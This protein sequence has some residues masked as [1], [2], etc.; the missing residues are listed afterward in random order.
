MDWLSK[1]KDGIKE[2]VNRVKNAISGV[3]NDWPPPAKKVL[4]KY[5]DWTVT[6][7]TLRRDPVQKLLNKALDLVSLGRWEQAKKEFGVNDLFHLG[8][9]VGLTSPTGKHAEI[10][11]EKNAV[12]NLGHPQAVND[13]TEILRVPPPSP[14]VTFGELM[15]NAQK[16][17][18][19]KFFLYSALNKNNCQ[20]FVRGVLR[21]SGALTEA[22]SEFLYQ[23]LSELVKA[24]PKH[25]APVADAITGL[26][27]RVDRII[28]GGGYCGAGSKRRRCVESDSEDSY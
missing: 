1:A 21:G 15:A 12:I 13:K 9:V 6:S 26:G 22:G 14:P 2:A 18:G 8:V 4:E 20:D 19:D 17:L 3:R 10:L 5:Q 25:L 11:A 27:A 24:Q 23:D 28:H 16:D 7:L